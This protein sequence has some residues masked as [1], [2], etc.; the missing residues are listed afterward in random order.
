VLVPLPHLNLGVR[1]TWLIAL[2]MD[3][4]EAGLLRVAGTSSR[5]LGASLMNQSETFGSLMHAMV[6]SRGIK[7]AISPDN[8]KECVDSKG[9][10]H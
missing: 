5:R 2:Q 7:L 6:D 8:K 1:R 4:R 10:Q 9:L 3:L